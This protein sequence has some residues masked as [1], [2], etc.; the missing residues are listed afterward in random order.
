MITSGAI[1]SVGILDMPSDVIDGHMVISTDYKLT[2]DPATVTGLDTGSTLSLVSLVGI[3]AQSGTFTVRDVRT[4]GDG[5]FSYA[6]LT[7]Q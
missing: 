3:P 2:Y 4:E 6:I 7:K 5:K 1:S